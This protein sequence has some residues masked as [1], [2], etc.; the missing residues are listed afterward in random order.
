VKRKLEAS[1]HA[2]ASSTNSDGGEGF[3]DV[4]VPVVAAVEAALA[5]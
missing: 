1:Q 4:G 3:V 2:L 5:V